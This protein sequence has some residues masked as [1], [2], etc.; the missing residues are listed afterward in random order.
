MTVPITSKGNPVVTFLYKIDDTW[1]EDYSPRQT[2]HDGENI[3]PL[4][5]PISGLDANSAKQLEVYMSVE[6]GEITI[7][8]ANCKAAVAGSSIASGFTEWDGKLVI[9]ESVNVVTMAENALTL[10]TLVDFAG[11]RVWQETIYGFADS[12][13]LIQL[14]NSM[15]LIGL[16]DSVEIE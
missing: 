16:S 6:G 9:E 2:L 10:K 1:I 15:S 14:E 13:S 8:P 4:F 7:A 3:L 11:T 5:Y 12:V